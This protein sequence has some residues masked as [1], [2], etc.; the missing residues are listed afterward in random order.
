MGV[1][2]KQEK[3]TN[4]V[5]SGKPNLTVAETKLIRMAR[6]F[7][8]ATGTAGELLVSYV[9][10]RA[11]SREA[12]QGRVTGLETGAE[13]TER[14]AQSAERQSSTA[15]TEV[16]ELSKK[17]VDAEGNVAS[18]KS[19][20][21]ELEGRA[22]AISDAIISSTKTAIETGVLDEEE[23]EDKTAPTKMGVLFGALA[24]HAKKLSENV[25][26]RVDSLEASLSSAA[27][28]AV[29][30][31][32]LDPDDAKEMNAGDKVATLLSNVAGVI[33]GLCKDVGTNTTSLASLNGA[34]KV[35]VP[36]TSNPVMEEEVGETPSEFAEYVARAIK[37]LYGQV[38]KIKEDLPERGAVDGL[39]SKHEGLEILM[40]GYN[41]DNNANRDRMAEIENK[42]EGLDQELKAAVGQL[43]VMNKSLTAM[44]EYLEG[45]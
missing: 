28:D 43:D 30:F 34:F 42:L 31:E 7:G 6:T 2:P 38:M 24:R 25:S 32:M 12:L 17:V 5:P 18:L 22:S 13:E 27:D 19:S 45:Q 36:K 16:S 20:V 39:A 11:A 33:Q 14:I 10:E 3:K 8:K 44:L 1:E 4:G 41:E 40:E 15:S 9:N 21:D 35:S 23:I 37:A 26:G 29:E